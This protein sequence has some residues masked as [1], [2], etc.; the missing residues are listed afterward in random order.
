[1]YE[2]PKGTQ[3]IA[4]QE[5]KFAVDD[6]SIDSEKAPKHKKSRYYRRPL[7]SSNGHQVAEK[8]KRKHDWLD[9]VYRKIIPEKEQSSVVGSADCLIKFLANPLVASEINKQLFQ[10][11]TA[12]D[13]FNLGLS[14][15]AI[16]SY[17]QTHYWSK[18]L[19]NLLTHTKLMHLPH[20]MI[21]LNNNIRGLV[22]YIT[23]SY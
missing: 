18:V 6:F 12:S 23:S 15:K 16:E 2:R 20:D 7:K 11:L 4:S 10:F 13:V 17:C 21:I 19:T 8:P 3:K 5:F 1:M 9:S 22:K 14:C